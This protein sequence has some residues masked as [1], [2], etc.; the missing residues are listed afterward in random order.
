[1]IF[2]LGISPVSLPL[3]A[4]SLGFAMREPPMYMG[5]YPKIIQAIIPYNQWFSPMV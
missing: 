1:M 4:P 5:I 2:Q 3:A